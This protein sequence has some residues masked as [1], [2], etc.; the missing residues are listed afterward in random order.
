MGLSGTTLKCDLI[1]VLV[2]HGGFA[3]PMSVSS[4]Y[5][6]VSTNTTTS[7][8]QNALNQ[9]SNNN[10]F[11]TRKSGGFQLIQANKSALWRYVNT[12]AQLD[13]SCRAANY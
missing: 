10:S 3:A 8:V 11:I 7:N 13:E 4:I 9:L 12:H 1:V 2:N 5:T 6:H